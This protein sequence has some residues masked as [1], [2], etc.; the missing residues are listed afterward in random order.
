MKGD[1]FYEK[2]PA[3]ILGLCLALILTACS[4]SKAFT[5]N[6]E[7]GDTIKVQLDTTNKYDLSA[8]LPFT[9]SR[10]GEA[11]SKGRFIYGS[12]FEDYQEIVDQDEDAVILETGIKDGN[13]YFLWSYQG[14][15]YNYV[16]LI[17]DSETAILICNQV[18]E[19]SARACFER[20][21]FTKES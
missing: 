8:S 1:I 20:L 5:Y 16:V 12:I 4:S 7:T 17:Q 14:T 9:I 18:S 21:T 15:E 2:V 13:S 19:E 6:V 11:L 3:L 10:D